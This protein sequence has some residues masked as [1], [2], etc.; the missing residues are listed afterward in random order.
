MWVRFHSVFP[1]S[2]LTVSPSLWASFS[3]P[4][5]VTRYLDAVSPLTWPV[6]NSLTPRRYCTVRTASRV[7]FF[8]KSINQSVF[9]VIILGLWQVSCFHLPF[10]SDPRLLSPFLLISLFCIFYPICRLNS[11]GCRHSGA[12]LFLYFHTTRS[13]FPYY[14]S[15]NIHC[16]YYVNY[17]DLIFLVR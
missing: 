14:P 15:P 6:I 7:I 1:F 2:L 5:W 16:V 12:L 4:R 13:R 10:G 17:K 11:R 8:S 9:I 3:H